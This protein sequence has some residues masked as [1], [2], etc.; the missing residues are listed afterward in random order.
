M[1]FLININYRMIS[2]TLTQTQ[3]STIYHDGHIMLYR[4][5]IAMNYSLS[6][7]CILNW[8]SLWLQVVLVLAMATTLKDWVVAHNF[9]FN[10][11]QRFKQ[12]PEYIFITQYCYSKCRIIGLLKRYQF[13]S[14]IF[15]WNEELSDICHITGMFHKL[16]YLQC[17]TYIYI[18]T[19]YY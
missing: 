3:L 16:T 5:H 13:L 1:I 2:V 10:L 17:S 8:N 7:S 6:Y 11:I 18:E 14:L 9:S 19:Y 4:V 15:I 12:Y